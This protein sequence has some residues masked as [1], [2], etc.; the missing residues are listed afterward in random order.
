[1]LHWTTSGDL[2]AMV[3][4]GG[5]GTLYGPVL[6]A[7]VL[8]V[9]QQYLAQWTEHWMILLGPFLVAIILF[10]RGGCGACWAGAGCGRRARGRDCGLAM[11]GF[12]EAVR[13]GGCDG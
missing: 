5:A 8:V 9:L 13:R 11:L 4:L 3:V 6:G 7:A 1:M 12:D 10:A 2:T